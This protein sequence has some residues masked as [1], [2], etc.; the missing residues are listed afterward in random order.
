MLQQLAHEHER[1]VALME[2]GDVAAAIRL[3]DHHLR[4]L[5]RRIFVKR[6]NASGSAPDG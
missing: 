3:M 6:K 1:I 2:R 4:D 5:E